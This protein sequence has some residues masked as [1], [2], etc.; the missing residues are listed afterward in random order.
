M[1]AFSL[2]C[3][4]LVSST[5]ITG[6]SALPL[7]VNTLGLLDNENPVLQAKQSVLRHLGFGL[8]TFIFFNS[9]RRRDE[10]KFQSGFSWGKNPPIKMEKIK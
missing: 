9:G 5:V 1:F 10:V 4:L 6:L 3:F 2:S 7:P 8:F